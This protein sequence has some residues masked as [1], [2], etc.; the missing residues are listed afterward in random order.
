MFNFNIKYVNACLRSASGDPVKRPIEIRQDP[1]TFRTSRVTFSRSEENEK[2]LEKL[3]HPPLEDMD[4]KNCPF[5]AGNIEKKTPMILEKL[6]KSGRFVY[7]ESILF[8]N[9]FPYTEW[10]GVS[11]FNEKHYVEIGTESIS[12]YRDCLINCSQYLSKIIQL[13]PDSV[14]MAITQNHLPAAGGSLV[15]PH[16]QVHATRHISNFH[17]VIKERADTHK[18]EFKTGLFSDYSAV[19]KKNGV[20]YIGDTGSWEWI[21]SFAPKGF[22]EIWGI[23]PG[24]SS[25][26]AVKDHKLW[27]DLATG[28]INIQRFYKSMNRN[29]YNLGILS[30]EDDSGIPELKVSITARSSY[31]PWVRSDITGFEMAFEEMATFSSPE[32][33]AD[34]ARNFWD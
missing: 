10:S 6:K 16:F 25:L 24:N 32:S 7:K 29:S 11:L 1:V 21:A 12:S 28:I 27:E 19:E 4:K 9:L 13:D 18:K 2:S 5:C 26:T 34:K 33:T 23:S 30:I 17:Q 14:F 15:H 8:P 20:R 31:A 22:Y 3:Y